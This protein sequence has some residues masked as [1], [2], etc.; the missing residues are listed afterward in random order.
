[1][2]LQRN[3]ILWNYPNYWGKTFFLDKELQ[4]Y[5]NLTT[6]ETLNINRSI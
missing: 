1:M 2:C 6:F 5:I 3:E 4:K